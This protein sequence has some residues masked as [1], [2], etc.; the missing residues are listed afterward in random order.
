VCDGMQGTFEESE[1]GWVVHRCVIGYQRASEQ[2]VNT[3]LL[4]STRC[5]NACSPEKLVLSAH[6]EYCSLV[7]QCLQ[8]GEPRLCG[9]LDRGVSA[10]VD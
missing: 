8:D 9:R 1:N 5:P 3:T 4:T 10:E 6:A 7:P 2:K